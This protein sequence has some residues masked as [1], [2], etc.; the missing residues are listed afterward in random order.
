MSDEIP[1][2]PAYDLLEAEER[3]LQDSEVA[4]IALALRLLCSK[5]TE[6]FPETKGW[7]RVARV[8]GIGQRL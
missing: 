8:E 5:E 4:A 1:F 6:T 2:V 7:S 3:K